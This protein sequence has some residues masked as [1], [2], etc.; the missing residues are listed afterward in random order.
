MTMHQAIWAAVN[1]LES[2]GYTFEGGEQWKPPI[3]Q[4]PKWVTATAPEYVFVSG[5]NAHTICEKKYAEILIR[6]MCLQNGDDQS[7]YTATTIPG[8]NIV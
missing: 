5:P 1:T 2:M 4:P 7:D 8:P 3:G 6:I